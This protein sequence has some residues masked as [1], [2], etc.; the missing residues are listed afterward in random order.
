[1]STVFHEADDTCAPFPHRVLTSTPVKVRIKGEW[2]TRPPQIFIIC[3]QCDHW[4]LTSPEC[5]C[6]YLCHD[7]GQLIASLAVENKAEIVTN[8]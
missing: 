1:M 7:L 6:D 4:I 5:T 2:I 3:A 8:S